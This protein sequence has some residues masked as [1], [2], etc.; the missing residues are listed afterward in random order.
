MVAPEQARN[1]NEDEA[2]VDST[3]PGK[4]DNVYDAISAKAPNAKVVVLGYPRFYLLGT[5]CLGLSRAKRTAIDN[6]ADCIDT[7]I[8]KRAADHGFTFGDVR[9]AFSSHEICSGS[10]WLR[11]V[12]WPVVT[13]SYRPTA[14]G[15][16]GGCPPVLAAHAA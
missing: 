12:N 1:E 7:A 16:S 2:Y 8:A 14:G 5:T 10:S 13:E 15:H 9:S 4:L 6:A 11:S 3:L